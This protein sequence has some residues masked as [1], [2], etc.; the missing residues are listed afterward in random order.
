MPHT[1]G[2][3]IYTDPAGTNLYFSAQNSS[4][5][6]VN[7]IA[8]PIAWT[9][10]Q[11]HFIALT[12]S[13]TNTA[14]YLDGQF[15][16]NGAGI[17]VLPSSTVLANGFTI[18][19]DTNGQSQAHGTLDDIYTYN[20]VLDTN[21]ISSTFSLFNPSYHLLNSWSFDNEDDI[22]ASDLGYDP[23]SF[24]NLT[25]TIGDNTAILLDTGTPAWLQ[26]NVYESDGRTNLTADQGSV[27][28]WFS[29]DWSSVNNFGSGPGWGQL[30]GVGEYT[31]GASYGWWSLYVDGDAT[32]LS[33][34]AQDNVGNQT[35]YL[36]VPI[37]WT[38]NKWH[39]LA[40]TYSATNT[41]LYIDG[42]LATN[43]VGMSVWPSST[44]LSNGLYFGS[45]TNGAAQA[46]GIYDD[47]ATYN[48]ALDSTAV[49]NLFAVE[50]VPYILNPLT[51]FSL[52]ITSAP[53]TPSYIP[54]YNE[55]TGLGALLLVSNAATC[56]Y[57]TNAYNVWITNVTAK[58]VGSGT[59]VTMNLTFTI[60][61]E[62]IQSP[63]MLSPIRCYPPARTA[64]LG[65]GWDRA[66]IA[67]SIRS[68]TCHPQPAS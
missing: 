55:I 22:W 9:P 7:Y 20:F 31:S 26:Y 29:P 65:R 64:F 18:G 66:L 46:R 11:W 3:S 8:A 10:G 23:V 63:M 15:A 59:N 5:S 38:A 45:D 2:G 16:T 13:S 17:S 43:G 19:S 49:S 27:T 30:F 1:D 56:S 61:G 34:G 24:T 40:L 21:T 52:N 57:G 6:Q 25:T 36:T 47:I 60:E 39:F 37:S 4:G 28:M 54:Q 50:A 44:V 32:N 58:A 42:T 62:R 67:M 53:S 68:R 33:F 51:A 35:N 14:L 41:A 48:I 12:Y